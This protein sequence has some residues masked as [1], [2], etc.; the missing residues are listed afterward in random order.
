MSARG[1]NR[2]TRRASRAG[3]GVLALAAVLLIAAVPT[4]ASAQVAS[5]F[6]G[7]IAEALTQ[8]AALSADGSFVINNIPTNTGRIFSVLVTCPGRQRRHRARRCRRRSRWRKPAEPRPAAVPARR[9]RA[10]A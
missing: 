7:C 10:P 8:S 3:R 9:R 5:T 1:R 4:I 6:D 2:D